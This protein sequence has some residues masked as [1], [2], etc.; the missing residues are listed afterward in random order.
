MNNVVSFAGR[1][2]DAALEALFVDNVAASAG[3]I[4]KG[5][6]K[7]NALLLAAT[8]Y[9]EDFPVEI[10]RY[11]RRQPAFKPIKDMMQKAGWQFC[12]SGFYS[13]AFFRNGLVIKVGF[14]AED[15]GLMYAAWCRANQGRAGVPVVHKLLSAGICYVVLMDRLEAIAG[16]L[17]VGSK[18]FDP[19][20]AAEVDSVKETINQGVD[21]WG[22]HMELCRT[23]IDIREFFMDI[24]NFDITE[25]NVM[26]DRNGNVV[27]TD[28]VSFA[29]DYVS[30]YHEDEDLDVA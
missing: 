17:E 15:S 16:E 22:Q 29:G 19:Q 11:V 24:C 21:G 10:G 3:E 2:D 27:I 23:A 8:A 13:A 12:G 14:K 18:Q 5:K 20:L 28:P 30:D 25:S 26:M 7:L 9:L 1:F 6:E 4:S